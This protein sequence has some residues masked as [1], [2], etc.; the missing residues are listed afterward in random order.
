LIR[1]DTKRDTGSAVGVTTTDAVRGGATGAAAAVEDTGVAERATGVAA[2]ECMVDAKD[3]SRAATKRGPSRRLSRAVESK[4]GALTVA[5]VG[6]VFADVKPSP[7]R[8]VA[9]PRCRRW[10]P[11][12]SG[13][14]GVLAG[15]V[16]EVE[17]NEV[18]AAVVAAD[19]DEPVIV[20]VCGP[21]EL[22]P[23]AFCGPR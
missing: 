23:G 11:G 13:V 1:V 2:A 6:L 7:G 5:G 20:L 12:V 19:A 17:V 4:A 16:D 14:A 9:P 21:P 22:L 8:E 10:V 15:P 18:R 3:G